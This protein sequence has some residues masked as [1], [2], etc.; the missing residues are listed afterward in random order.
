MSFTGHY[1]YR[2]QGSL[3]NV[4]FSCPIASVPAGPQSLVLSPGD[5]DPG[6]TYTYVLRPVLNGVITPDV[7]CATTFT[8]DAAGQWSGETPASPQGLTIS[9]Q[10]ASKVRLQWQYATP[11]GST[12]PADFVIR[13]GKALPLDASVPP[14]AIVAYTHDGTYVT[15]LAALGT[16]V[17]TLEARSTAGTR[18]AALTAGPILIHAP[19]LTAPAARCDAVA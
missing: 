2:G 17:F 15:D 11:A 19:H 6:Q 9:V 5:H 7:S 14:T 16:R 8:I 13:T 18:S 12:P 1:L 10:P 4:D 3:A